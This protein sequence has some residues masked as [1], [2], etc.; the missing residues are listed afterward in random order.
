[1]PTAVRVRPAERADAA[2]VLTLIR[3]LAEYERLSGEVRAT[4]ELIAEHLFGPQPAAEALIAEGDAGAGDERGQPIGFALF[5]TTFSTFLG[6]PGI[7]LEDVFVRPQHR[8][9]GVGRALLAELARLAVQR[10]HGRLEWAALDWNAPAL[11]FY[12]GLGAR[13]MDDWITHRLDGEAL[14]RLASSGL[15]S[16][17]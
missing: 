15:A 16:S 3:E 5:F 17:E 6:R 14:R 2:L 13:P 8:R 4:D 9:R 11:G 7:W 12:R 1:M 10:G